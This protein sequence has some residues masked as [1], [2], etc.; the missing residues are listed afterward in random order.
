MAKATVWQT[1]KVLDTGSRQKFIFACVLQIVLAIIDTAGVFLVG[2]MVAIATSFNGIS[3]VPYVI[4]FLEISGLDSYEY[5][6]Q[7]LQK[8]PYLLSILYPIHR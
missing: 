8:N 5:Q 3:S 2:M 6:F 1:L 7:L 4:R